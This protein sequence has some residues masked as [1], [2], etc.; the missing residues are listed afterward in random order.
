M[1]KVHRASARL[2]V[3]AEPGTL[4][5]E[6][7]GERQGLSRR[8]ALVVRAAAAGMGSEET[9]AQLGMTVRDVE[10]ALRVAMTKLGA[11]SRIE[12]VVIA[13]RRG[14]IDRPDGR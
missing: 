6:P 4:G 2:A 14:L 9:A 12:A 13:I 11:G 10:V 7:E 5:V 3:V 8:E 1:R